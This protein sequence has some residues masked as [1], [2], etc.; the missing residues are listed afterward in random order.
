MPRVIKENLGFVKMCQRW[1]MECVH[2]TGGLRQ[3]ELSLILSALK[4][5][6]LQHKLVWADQF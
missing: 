3:C 1:W 5:T 2:V 6:R 4:Y